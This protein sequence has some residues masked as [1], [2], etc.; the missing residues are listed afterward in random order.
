MEEALATSPLHPCLWAHRSTVAA[1]TNPSKALDLPQQVGVQVGFFPARRA[2]LLLR[3]NQISEDE[4]KQ[5]KNKIKEVFNV[6]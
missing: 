6:S 4:K 2:H 5:I 3:Q 1:P